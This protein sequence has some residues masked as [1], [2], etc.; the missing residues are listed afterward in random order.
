MGNIRGGLISGNGVQINLDGNS[1]ENVTFEYV[2][3]VYAG[4]APVS[5]DNCTY[6][7]CKVVL[8]GVANQRF[9][10]MIAQYEANPKLIE[11]IYGSL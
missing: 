5:L 11:S 1:Y 9:G 10:N 4:T 7:S 2:T 3:F 6:R 8:T